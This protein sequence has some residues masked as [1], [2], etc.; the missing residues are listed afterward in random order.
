M[1]ETARLNLESILSP[2]HV[3]THTLFYRVYTPPTPIKSARYSACMGISVFYGRVC[4]WGVHPFDA[5]G[6]EEPVFRVRL[7]E[8]RVA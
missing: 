4:P 5:G 7:R 2:P 1:A 6:L 8:W 3:S